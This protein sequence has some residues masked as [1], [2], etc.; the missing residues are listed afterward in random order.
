MIHSLLTML[1]GCGIR[2]A[3]L[4]ALQI[5]AASLE[6]LIVCLLIPFMSAVGSGRPQVPPLPAVPIGFQ[7]VPTSTVAAILIGAVLGRSLIQIAAAWYWSQSVFHFEHQRRT[8]LVDAFTAS[9]WECQS[10]EPSGKLQQLL[11]TNVEQVAKVF[12]AAAYSLTHAVNLIVLTA[13]AF[14]VSVVN[15]IAALVVLCLL[16]LA[17]RPLSQG[18]RAAATKR[19]DA[20]AN[21]AN[22]VSQCVPLMKELRV[23]G[24]ENRFTTDA[25]QCSNDIGSTRRRQNFFGAV[26]PVIYQN[27][28]G[29]LLV[30][31]AMIALVTGASTEAS[32]AIVS[33]LL[34]IRA[35]S[36]GQHLHLMLHQLQEC[37]PYLDQI[38][39]AQSLYDKH[40]PAMG[41]DSL[42]HIGEIEFDRVHFSYDG[43]RPALDDVSFRVTSGDVV[44]VVGPSGAGKS[45]LAQLLL[46]LRS[47]EQGEVRINGVSRDSLAAAA[48]FARVAY[49]PQDLT[50]LGE[51]VEECI[52]FRRTNVSLEQIRRA[53]E[54]AGISDE[55]EQMPQAFAT[56]VGERGATL[57]H[58][59]RQ[60]LCI[61]RALAGDPDLIVFDEPTSALDPNSEARVLKTARELRGKKITFILA[62]RAATLGVC[63][64]VLVL[65]DG[66]LTAF[67]DVDSGI[68]PSVY[69]RELVGAVDE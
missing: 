66:R 23:F 41:G 38:A 63:N 29:L 45:T 51:S 16:A 1:P 36:Y 19:A 47:P 20:L 46:G 50:L 40:R 39:A 10:R 49:V 14:T 48:W 4:C 68:E 31:G 25:A 52:R 15:S 55:I 12:T 54:Q 11:T 44:A 26:V 61:A 34:L 18:T 43:R 33:V 3:A 30:G 27:G 53:A 58:G 64:K 9:T 8:R 21:Y 62:H 13:Y 7:A 28:S 22:L 57:S 37:V 17:A 35:V 24:I 67:H 60:R 5:I 69:Y 65:R 6:A 56:P 42:D 32:T 2:L 59:Q